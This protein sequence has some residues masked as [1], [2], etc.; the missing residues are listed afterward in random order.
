MQAQR[1]AERGADADVAS[2]ERQLAAA[3]QELQAALQEQGALASASNEVCTEPHT[4]GCIL[5]PPAVRNTG[6][7]D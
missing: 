6:P 4:A 7:A 3:Q 2:A 1:A 5:P